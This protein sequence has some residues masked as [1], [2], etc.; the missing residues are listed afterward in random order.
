MKK[1]VSYPLSRKKILP[2]YVKIG[3]ALMLLGLVSCTQQPEQELVTSTNTEFETLGIKFTNVPADSN[4]TADVEVIVLYLHD[5]N[6]RRVWAGETLYLRVPK[7]YKP[8]PFT[9]V[10]VVYKGNVTKL[11]VPI[12]GTSIPQ[13]VSL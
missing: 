10:I 5:K 12:L 4:W 13:T 2:G 8:V 6:V 7:G 1:P 3:V 9:N 11:H